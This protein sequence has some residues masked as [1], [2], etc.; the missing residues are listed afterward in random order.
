M[1]YQPNGMDGS[2]VG[3][4]TLVET[5]AALFSGGSE[6]SGRSRLR[7]TNMST[8]TRARIGRVASNLQRDG[9]P[10]EPGDTVTV[11]PSTTIYGC[12]E[13]SAITCQI[14]EK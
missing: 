10:I 6:L 5:P 14:E 2:V 9:A 4:K 3:V 7:V 13:G 8:A 1:S 11:Y 12:S